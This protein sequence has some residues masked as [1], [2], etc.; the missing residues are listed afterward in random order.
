MRRRDCLLALGLIVVPALAH[1]ASVRIVDQ[2]I[3]RVDAAPGEY[4]AV[5]VRAIPV[6][7]PDIYSITDTGTHDDGSPIVLSAVDPCAAS[8]TAVVCPAVG[9]ESLEIYL[10][11]K[12]DSAAVGDPSFYFTSGTDGV[13]TQTQGVPLDTYIDGGDGNDLLVGDQSAA[14][15]RDVLRGGPGNDG[16]A[17]CRGDDDLDGGPGTDEVLDWHPPMGW[18]MRWQCLGG[19]ANVL[20]GGG[21]DPAYPQYHE[22]II[23]GP[24]SDTVYGSDDGADDAW[25]YDGD[26]TIYGYGGDDWLDGG[27]E[28]LT[29]ADGSDTLYGNLGND[30]LAGRYGSDK[31]YGGGGNDV[32][33]AGPG[34]DQLS[35]GSGQD[36]LLGGCAI[37]LFP[38][39][40]Y[41]P[42]TGGDTYTANDGDDT[43][44]AGGDDG[45][46]DTVSCGAGVDTAA[47]DSIDSVG[48]DCEG[49]TM[50]SASERAS[51]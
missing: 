40:T 5:G 24:G 46:K 1:G 17:G 41:E 37:T 39:L 50:L 49:L 38:P 12:D 23:G 44:Q 51:R 27:F 9:I 4:N 16:L 25:G 35:G 13:Y 8:G 36:T 11:D 34:N 32:L 21:V 22:R 6:G 42:G 47:V 7:T 26:D 2:R 18:P 48:T 29:I 10:D 3:I 31:L 30:T 15:A 43:I 19:G 28:K 33:C 20:R 14:G 45:I